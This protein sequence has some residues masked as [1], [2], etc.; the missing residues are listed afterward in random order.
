MSDLEQVVILVKAWP[1]PSLKYGETVCCAGVT[2]DGAW[3]RLFPIRF[4]HLSGKAQFK[5]WD[6][7]RYRSE[8]PKDDSRSESRRVHEDSLAP[9][10]VLAK[11]SRERLLTPLIRG[12]IDDAAKAGESLTL[13]RPKNIKFIVRKKRENELVRE[14]NQRKKRAAQTNLFDPELIELEACPYRLYLAFEDGAGR[15]RMECGDWETAATYFNFSKR[16]DPGRALEHLRQTYEV[17]YPKRGVVLAL[18]TQKKRPRQWLLL[19]I[20]RLDE[21]HQPSLL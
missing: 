14:Q 13:I 15:H 7:L 12:S 16:Y 4:R 18:G 19:G 6:L 17:D 20:I 1:Q 11:T 8:S 3:R 9:Q 10:G 21:S 2:L 5:R